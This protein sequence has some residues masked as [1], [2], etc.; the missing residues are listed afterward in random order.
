MIRR[1]E[2]VLGLL[3]VAG[4][5]SL[6]GVFL[7]HSGALWRDEVNS[8]NLASASLS[9]FRDNLQF[10]SFPIFWF[11]VLRVWI[12]SG[13]GATDFGL[14]LLGGSRCCGVGAR[15]EPGCSRTSGTNRP[16]STS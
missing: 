11:V 9:E 8:V 5:L 13:L 15:L 7:A 6:H 2:F 4:L 12:A 14:R 1:I 10:D 16:T 3:L